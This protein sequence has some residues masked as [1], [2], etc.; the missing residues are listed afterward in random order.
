[1]LRRELHRRGPVGLDAEIPGSEAP[2]VPAGGEDDRRARHGPCPGLELRG[3]LARGQA[4]DID[5]RNAD[6][7]GDVPRR[8]SEGEPEA[9]T[10]HDRNG[11]QREQALDQKPPRPGAAALPDPDRACA[12][13]HA[14]GVES[15]DGVCGLRGSFVDHS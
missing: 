9:E 8:P 1:M 10:R 11:R 7:F 4:A 13:F 12:C 6:A 15:S 2:A 5:A 3:R 14:Q